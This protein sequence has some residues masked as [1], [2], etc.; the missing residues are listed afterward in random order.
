MTS[1]SLLLMSWFIVTV[2]VYPTLLKM[3][4]LPNQPTSYLL[5]KST[6]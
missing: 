6:A 1:P 3:A 4:A 5:A 2:S